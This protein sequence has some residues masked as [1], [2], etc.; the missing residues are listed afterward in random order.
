MRNKAKKS[1]VKKMWHDAG[2]A[3]KPTWLTWRRALEWLK[4]G[5]QPPR[6]RPTSSPQERAKFAALLSAHQYTRDDKGNVIPPTASTS[7]SSSAPPTTNNGAARQETNDRGKTPPHQEPGGGLAHGDPAQHLQTGERG[8]KA[9]T[10]AWQDHQQRQATNPYLNQQG[11]HVPRA[12]QSHLPPRPLARPPRDEQLRLQPT[13]SQHPREQRGPNPDP[14]QQ[15]SNTRRVSFSLPEGHREEPPRP[16]RTEHV[17]R[18]LTNSSSTQLQLDGTDNLPV[19]VVD[20]RPEYY[21]GSASGATH[22]V[23]TGGGPQHGDVLF[24]QPPHLTAA[25]SSPSGSIRTGH[26]EQPDIADLESEAEAL[27]TQG[28]TPPWHIED[29]STSMRASIRVGDVSFDI[30]WLQGAGPPTLPPMIPL[31]PNVLFSAR[32]TAAGH[33]AGDAMDPPAG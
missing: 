19:H 26:P 28:A 30:S 25:T 1:D 6:K 33:V 10:Q 11:P 20:N 16:M 21:R 22:H 18:R 23:A 17:L 31:A 15:P 32:G 14:P 24:V 12:P 13:G 4:R 2:W 7:S 3:P 9:T 5:E 8:D 29:S 27:I